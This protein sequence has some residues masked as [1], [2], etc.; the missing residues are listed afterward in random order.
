MRPVRKPDRDFPVNQ[1]RSA[2]I[3]AG[4]PTTEL[5][6]KLIGDTNMHGY[7]RQPPDPPRRSRKPG[8]WLIPLIAVVVAAAVVIPI[9]LTNGDHNRTSA[10]TTTTSNTE[11]KRPA[12]VRCAPQS[13]DTCFPDVDIQRD[14]V[15]GSQRLGYTCKPGDSRTPDMK[16]KIWIDPVSSLNITFSAPPYDP[17]ASTKL[18]TISVM[19][20]AAAWG[21]NPKDRS[22]DSIANAIRSFRAGLS[23][24]FPKNPEMQREILSWAQESMGHCQNTLDPHEIMYGYELQCFNPEA[25]G[26]S[27]PKGPMTQW[28]TTIHVKGP[29]A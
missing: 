20:A 27:G 11:P 9:M 6:N 23:L 14:L 3:R 25:T 2:V 12:P 7:L 16:C 13:S 26:V 4:A 28:T 29:Y 18:N 5:I 19:G 21:Y 10:D 24:T 15:P 8:P 22:Q 1:P 17:E